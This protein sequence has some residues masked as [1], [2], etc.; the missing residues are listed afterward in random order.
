[1]NMTNDGQ[2][3]LKKRY[4]RQCNQL[5]SDRYVCGECQSI[6]KTIESIDYYGNWGYVS[7]MQHDEWKEKGFL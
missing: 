6:L 2:L 4:C 3:W 1:M 5:C 7:Q